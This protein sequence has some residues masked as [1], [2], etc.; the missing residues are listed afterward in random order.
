MKP[1]DSASKA[2]TDTTSAVER[3]IHLTPSAHLE[4]EADDAK[5]A[6]ASV[7]QEMRRQLEQGVDPRRLA[8]DH[9]WVA[10]GSAAVAGF[11]AAMLAV[12]SPEDAALKRLE[13]IERALQGAN[14]QADGAAHGEP[15]AEASKHSRLLRLF[16]R[17][18]FKALQPTLMAALTS[19]FTARA[20]AAEESDGYT[21]T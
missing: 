5:A 17:R 1:S 6:I 14:G 21:A 20:A 12:P 13:R 9:P 11:V 3:P 4:L 19:L 7:L 16:A 15:A 2:S 18:L 10:V 8:R